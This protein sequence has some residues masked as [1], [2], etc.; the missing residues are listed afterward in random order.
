M[1]IN[2]LLDADLTPLFLI[3]LIVIIIAIPTGIIMGSKTNKTIYGD[4]DYDTE[5]ESEI[6]KIIAMRS[7]PHPLNPAI[8]VNTVVFELENTS[9]IELAIK[10]PVMYSVM[11]EGD[12]GL[13]KHQGNKFISFERGTIDE[14]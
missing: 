2:D 14:T 8:M 9:R 13:L 5:S 12:Y 3:I 4:D 10:D 11:I 7:K 6:A 1:S